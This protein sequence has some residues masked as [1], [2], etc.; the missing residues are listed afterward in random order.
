[1]CFAREA[2]KT[3]EAMESVI[4]TTADD[5]CHNAVGLSFLT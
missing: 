4:I 3:L 2:F 5:K 1:M